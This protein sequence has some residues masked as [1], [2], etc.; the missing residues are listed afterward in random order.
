MTCIFTVRSFEEAE[1][2][3]LELYQDGFGAIELCGAFGKERAARLTELTNHEVA[4]GYVVHEPEL[5]PLF[6]QFF[7]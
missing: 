2:K 3:V 1:E 6:D 5:D 4:I 7:S